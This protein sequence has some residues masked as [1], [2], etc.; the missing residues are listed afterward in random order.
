MKTSVLFSIIAL[1]LTA[2]INAANTMN[3]P[4]NENALPANV[5]LSELVS[6]AE[7]EILEVSE[8]MTDAEAFEVNY[9]LRE[10][11]EWMLDPTAFEKPEV[12]GVAFELD[13]SVFEDYEE[14]LLQV[15]PWMLSVESYD[16]EYYEAD[17]EEKILP[18]EDW[19]FNF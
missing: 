2:N 7:E 1:A 3:E 8:W 10:I 5:N 12:K 11:E 15:E 14:E 19:M 6:A 13:A 4:R 18:I 17:Y 16:L 9:E